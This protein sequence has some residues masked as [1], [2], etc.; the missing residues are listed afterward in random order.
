V[1]DEDRAEHGAAHAGD[2]ADADDVGHQPREE[3]VAAARN[4]QELGVACAV[5]VDRDR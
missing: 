5:G 4:A 3:A 1:A 2:G